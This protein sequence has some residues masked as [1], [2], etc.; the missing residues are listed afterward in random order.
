MN[1]RYLLVYCASVSI[2]I[3][4]VSLVVL[5]FHCYSLPVGHLTGVAAVLLCIFAVAVAPRSVLE[6]GAFGA[7]VMLPVCFLLSTYA[8]LPFSKNEVPIRL[9][10]HFLSD[11]IYVSVYYVACRLLAGLH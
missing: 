2:T 1:S 10:A 5:H 3:L 8:L 11:E 6:Q 4:V 7:A 9:F